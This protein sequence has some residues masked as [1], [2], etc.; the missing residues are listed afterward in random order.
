MNEREQGKVLSDVKQK[1]GISETALA[2]RIGKPQQWVNK[3]IR[4]ALNLRPDVVEA[5]ENDKIT[6]SVAEVISTLDPTLQGLFLIYIL[7]NNIGRNEAEVRKAKK[8]FLNNTIYTIGHDGRKLT[9]FIQIL[10]ENGIEYVLDIR[11]S[12]ESSFESGV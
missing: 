2:K 4:I 11:F 3:R 5:L 6:M 10:K 1:L 8:R 7:E 12:V 9:D